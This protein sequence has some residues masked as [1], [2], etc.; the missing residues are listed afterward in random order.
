MQHA[1]TLPGAPSPMSVHMTYQFAE[2]HSFAYGKRQRLREHGLWLVD[3]DEYFNGK[4]V[5]ASAEHATL[6]RKE[7]GERVDSRDAVKY[8]GTAW[9]RRDASRTRPRHV[10]MSHRSSTTWR[11]RGTART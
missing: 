4:Y 10:R 2:G 5:T 9:R 3:P 1:H 11:R 7:M 6:P 8:R